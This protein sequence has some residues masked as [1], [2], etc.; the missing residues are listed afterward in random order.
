MA[1]LLHPVAPAPLPIRLVGRAVDWTVI[2][3]GGA[4]ALLVFF[5]VSLHLFSLDLSL[6]HI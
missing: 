3:I 6:I 2:A 1:A 5:N 4:M